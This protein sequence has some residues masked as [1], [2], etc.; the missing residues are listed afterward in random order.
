MFAKQ[1]FAQLRTGLMQH[2]HHQITV[3][4]RKIIKGLSLRSSI[5]KGNSPENVHSVFV[6]SKLLKRSHNYLTCCQFH[7]LH[8]PIGPALLIFIFQLLFWSSI[9]GIGFLLLLLFLCWWNIV[10]IGF[11][12]LCWSSILGIVFH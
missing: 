4:T 12:F 8:F 3:F 7:L 9:V 5:A 1:M 2:C 11:L 6:L 10:G